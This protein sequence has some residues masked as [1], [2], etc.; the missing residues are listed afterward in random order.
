MALA[1]IAPMVMPSSTRSPIQVGMGPVKA[2][3]GSRVLRG[4][5]RRRGAPTISRAT[6]ET[7]TPSPAYSPRP[8]CS[9][10]AGSGCSPR[11][12]GSTPRRSRRPRRTRSASRRCRRHRERARV[13]LG[14]ITTPPMTKTTT[15]KGKTTRSKA[16][17]KLWPRNAIAIWATTTISRQ[18]LSFGSCVE[19]EGAAH[20]VDREPAD[21]GHDRVEPRRQ[22]VAEEAERDPGQDH[23]RHA[24]L[25]PRADRKPWRL[26]RG[27]FPARWPGWPSHGLAEEETAITPTN[28]VANS[29]LGD[30]QVKNSRIGLP[31]RSSSG[32]NSAPPGSIVAILSPYVPSR[33]SA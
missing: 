15:R 21:A 30:T 3:S 33:T 11:R 24:G 5:D 25:G 12:K 31:W 17:R 13:R 18:S 8:A 16:C 7:K 29:I 23:L 32:M 20:A 6:Q 27:R 9:R 14:E 4:R 10:S 28:T 1:E 19:G 22:R 2:P 26:S